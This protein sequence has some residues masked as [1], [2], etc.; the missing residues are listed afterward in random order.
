[1]MHVE[2]ISERSKVSENIIP[3][4]FGK[5]FK[6]NTNNSVLARGIKTQ[7]LKYT[8]MKNHDNTT[9]SSRITQKTSATV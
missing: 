4:T 6:Y 1:M 9:N 2:S 5:N 8:P 7:K 3:S